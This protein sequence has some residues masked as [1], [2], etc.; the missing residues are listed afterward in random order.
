MSR[1][2]IP[3]NPGF[4]RLEFYKPL[5]HLTD[6]TPDQI[7]IIGWR[8]YDTEDPSPVCVG[9]EVGDG[10]V[11]SILAPNGKVYGYSGAPIGDVSEWTDRVKSAVC[12]SKAA[13][14]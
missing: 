12:K 14:A 1:I 6:Y 10:H 11:T 13:V 2:T 5:A 4:Y 7:P 8:I 9:G 3:A